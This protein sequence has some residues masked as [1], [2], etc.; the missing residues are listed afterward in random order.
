MKN[1]KKALAFVNRASSPYY[2]AYTTTGNLPS[3]QRLEDNLVYVSRKKMYVLLTTSST[4]GGRGGGGNIS[5]ST[6][7]TRIA[8]APPNGAN[9]S[10]DGIEAS[11]LDLIDNNEEQKEDQ[12]DDNEALED[13]M[14]ETWTFT[15]FITFALL[16][17]IVPD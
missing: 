3:G 2:Q 13:L 6:G 11:S 5:T 9:N 10:G 15:G 7:T 4:A 14:A 16:G 12:D 17:P 1:C 8:A